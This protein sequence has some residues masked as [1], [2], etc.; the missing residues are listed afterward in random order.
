MRGRTLFKIVEPLLFLFI[1]LLRLLPFSICN[2]LWQMTSFIPTY[3]GITLRYCFVK[4]LAKSVGTNVYIGPDVEI[5][6]W[7]NLVIG[8]NVSIHR[9]CY[10]DATGG[11][12]IGSNVSI[13]H[14]S[15]LISFEHTWDNSNL[16]IRDNQL[17][18]AKIV[19]SDDV[20]IGCGCRI[21]AGVSIGN[22]SI[23]A[24]GA[25]VQKNVDAGS[26]VGGVPAKMIKIISERCS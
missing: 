9:T 10:L 3:L 24:A 13:A 23:V 15:S 6:G 4:R 12:L 21:L 8:S 20:W 19:L 22:R 7:R 26:L 16:P 11:I 14:Q 18:L 17:K 2:F 5:R 1:F 25:V